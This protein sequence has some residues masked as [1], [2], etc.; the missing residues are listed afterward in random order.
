LAGL[1]DAAVGRPGDGADGEDDRRDPGRPEGFRFSTD[2]QLEARIRDVADLYLDP[3]ENAVVVCIYEKSQCQSLEQTQPILPMR[4]GIPERQTHDYARHGVTCLFA[5]LEIAT[6]K[7][8]DACYPRHR[9]QAALRFLKK[10]GTAH[11]GGAA[12]GVRPLCSA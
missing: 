5:A 12:R 2:P 1:Q 6:R 4:S 8:T 9:H 3:P 10:T 7:I 11:P